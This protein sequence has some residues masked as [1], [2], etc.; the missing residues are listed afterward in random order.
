[1]GS[2][3]SYSSLADCFGG[4]AFDENDQNEGPKKQPASDGCVVVR[5]DKEV[6]IDD[7]DI[8]T[9]L[10]PETCKNMPFEE[11][12]ALRKIDRAYHMTVK[13]FW[14]VLFE[15]KFRSLEFKFEDSGK[16]EVH[17]SKKFQDSVRWSERVWLQAVYDILFLSEEGHE[18]AAEAKAQVSGRQQKMDL[19]TKA[20]AHVNNWQAGRI[21]VDPVLR[22][23]APWERLPSG[24][25]HK[26]RL[27]GHNRALYQPPFQWV[28]KSEDVE[29]VPPRG[30]SAAKSLTEENI[31]GLM[32]IHHNPPGFGVGADT[33]V[34]QPTADEG[35]SVLQL[36]VG[37]SSDSSPSGAVRLRQRQWKEMGV[38]T[39]SSSAG[40]QLCV[41]VL[42]FCVFLLFRRHFMV[43][44]KES[45]YGLVKGGMVSDQI[46]G[47]KKK[48][49]KAKKCMM[50][51]VEQGAI[52]DLEVGGQVQ[53]A[54]YDA[55][56]VAE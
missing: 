27:S 10:G 44:G 1:M 14:H 50:S 42:V 6:A 12:L 5:A 19:L 52:L 11:F 2:A 26:T 22:G 16:L 34:L 13:I 39:Y 41:V 36:A 7:W 20:M 18:G 21:D 8:N 48:G 25:A 49:R 51:D 38:A 40:L 23:G 35:L 9:Q 37:T 3:Q 32:K 46:T 56:G 24:W 29:L 53:T 33:S 30:T 54:T 47:N 55:V 28:E 31:W 43:K 17:T 4:S 15:S 45:E